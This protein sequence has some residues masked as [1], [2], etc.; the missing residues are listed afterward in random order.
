VRWLAALLA[1]TIAL[2]A[3]AD[4]LHHRLSLAGGG[5]LYATPGFNGHGFGLV[6]YD[7]DGLPRGSHFAAELNTDTLRLSYDRIRIG[8]FELGVA[9]A[10]EAFIAGL[11]TDY[12]RD[13][14][15]DPARGFYAS[16]ATLGAAA[17]LNLAP[18]FVELAVDA[19]RWFFS[20]AGATSAALVLPPETWVGE[21]RLNYTLWQLAND[22][23]LW[24][25]QRLF[26]RLRGVAF[27]VELGLDAR[28]DV[29]PW[30]AR[31]PAA[32]AP[33]D[34]RNDPSHA[35]WMARQWLRAGI[36][37]QRR[38]RLQIDEVVSWMQGADDLVRLR[39]GGLNPYSVSLVGAP[40]AGYLADELAAAQASLHIRVAGEQEIGLL[41][42]GV[43]LDDVNRTGGSAARPGL[44]AGIGLFADLRLGA[45]QLDARGGWSPTTRPGTAAGGFTL[46]VSVGWGWAR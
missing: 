39:V 18:H 13:G 37:V 43:A 3:A 14:Q 42:D 7:L 4:G 20:R 36:V 29:Q 2:P 17:K 40:W 6:R 27:G 33:P 38:L 46:F 28:S 41:V 21:V 24:E 26:P 1:T 35:I 16:Y 10:G 23:S 44:L 19:R 31:D 5:E 32:F 22:R 34:L 12:Y 30:G 11:L 45:W 8:R 15:N 9:A 25:P